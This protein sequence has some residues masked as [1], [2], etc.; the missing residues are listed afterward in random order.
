VRGLAL[1]L[2]CAWL[3]LGCGGVPL[4]EA[5]EERGSSLPLTRTEYPRA[6]ELTWRSGRLEQTPEAVLFEFTLLN[7][8]TRDYLSVMLRLV[9]RG[10]DRTL[11]TVRYPAG[12][13][14]AGATRRIRA[15]LAPPGFAVEAAELEL[16][17][18]QE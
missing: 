10:P 8:T 5:P 3:A 1:A 13:I 4:Y 7:G 18:A 17:F 15:H 16:I 9:L 12:P 6:G 14:A 11:A 2:G